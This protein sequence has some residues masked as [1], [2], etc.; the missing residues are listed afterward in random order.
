VTRCPHR[1]RG[2]ARA[3][4]R[5][6]AGREE[7][8]EAVRVA[9]EVRAGGGLARAFLTLDVVDEGERETNT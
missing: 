2:H 9:A 6:G 7:L 8:T 5:A 3:A 1:I 4:P